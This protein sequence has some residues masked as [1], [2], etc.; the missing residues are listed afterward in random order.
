MAW[1]G[2]TA[3]QVDADSP[4][5]ETLITGLSNDILLVRTAMS[6]NGSGG[7]KAE[8]DGHTHDNSDSRALATNS[9]SQGQLNANVS[10]NVLA[11][12][13]GVAGNYILTGERWGWWTAGATTPTAGGMV[14]GNGNVARGSIGLYNN[15][16]SLQRSFFGDETYIQASP[17]YDLGDGD[18]PLFIYIGLNAAGDII[19]FSAAP[20]PVWA[21]NGPTDVVPDFY[22][23]D[24]KGYQKQLILP[25]G[26]MNTPD[27]PRA[28][29]ARLKDIHEFR[30]TAGK[31]DFEEIKITHAIKNADMN[32]IPH[33]FIGCPQD[34]ITMV[35]LDPVSDLTYELLL[36]LEDGED[37]RN[38]FLDGYF[39]IDNVELGR[40]RPD[41]LMSVSYKWKNS[42]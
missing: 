38:L 20:D 37:I 28:R 42:G 15:H 1:E 10:L 32:I 31:N 9:V 34:G 24:G 14:F 13:A 25:P 4:V 39:E 21:Y 22:S 41:A 35:M 17:P 40:K 6:G 8:G 29:G 30:K 7:F 23:K 27:N 33:N 3:G 11:L 18:I 36:M 26:L 16:A 19:Y 5:D 2:R 12:N